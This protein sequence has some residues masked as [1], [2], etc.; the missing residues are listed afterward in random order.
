MR[1]IKNKLTF[2]HTSS[3]NTK[4]IQ[5]RKGR[6]FGYQVL[7]FGAGGSIP[8]INFLV[9]GGGG[10]GGYGNPA[11]G[12]GGAGGG[13]FRTREDVYPDAGQ[14]ISVA[15]GGGGSGSTGGN[16]YN[17]GQQ[18]NVQGAGFSIA[19]AGGA[20]GGGGCNGPATQ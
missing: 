5:N 14:T 7:G 19:S 4:N 11:S 1:D 20:G 3:K 12:G 17:A 6:S 10:G 16:P 8:A 13:G 2:K 18:S 9:V 15:I